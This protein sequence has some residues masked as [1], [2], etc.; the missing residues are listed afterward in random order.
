MRLLIVCNIIPFELLL[1]IL[2]AV[3][4]V[5]IFRAVLILVEL[6]ILLWIGRFAIFHKAV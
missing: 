6:N 5:L 4:I 2:A 1:F 3:K